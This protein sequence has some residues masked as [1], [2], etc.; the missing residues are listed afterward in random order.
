MRRGFTLIELLVVIAVLGVLAAGVFTAINPLKRINQANDVRIKSDIG[1]IAN[2]MQAF[3][4]FHQYYPATLQ[5]LKDNG[6]LKTIPTRPDDGS[7]YDN[8]SSYFCT[9]DGN[10]HC[11]EVSIVVSLAV[12]QTP[13]SNYGWNSATGKAGE[14][15]PPPTPTATPAP[16][17]NGLY[18]GDITYFSTNDCTNLAG[19]VCDRDYPAGPLT[20][21]IYNGAKDA[22]GVLVASGQTTFTW[23]GTNVASVCGTTAQSTGFSFST[24]QI[25]RDGVTHTLYYYGISLNT[26]GQPGSKG[27][28][29][30]NTGTSEP[31]KC[32]R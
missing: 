24:P 25:L 22:G 21:N 10:G 7:A 18:S 3:Y 17:N 32:P 13:G 5:E 4:T 11:T 12:P 16:D 8:S 15:S 1:Q 26:N 27:E 2:A 31:F 6:D 23:G 29:P 30:F 28:V 19:W 14:I 20:I 9:L